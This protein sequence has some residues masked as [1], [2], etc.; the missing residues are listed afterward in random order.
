[1]S[2]RDEAA[3]V[4]AVR[5]LLAAAG[6]LHED[7]ARLVP[8][9]VRATAL[10]PEGVE[11]G[12]AS[13]E[14]EATEAELRALVGAAGDASHV[15]VILSANVFVAPLR[16]IALARAAAPRVTVR[17]SSRDP[18]LAEALVACAG[19]PAIAITRGKAIP[20]G[21]ER[22]DVYGRDETI[23]EVRA[24]ARAGVAVR[25]HGAGLGVAF[26]RAADPLDEAASA[27][28]ADVVPFD[29]RGCLSPR[30][31]LAEGPAARGAALAE[32][33]DASLAAWSSR[34]PRGALTADERAEAARWRDAIVFAGRVWDAADHATAH[35][36]RSAEAS[37][38]APSAV[39]P[40]GRHVLVVSAG[41]GVEAALRSIAP[42]VVTVGLL[43]GGAR[44]A[45][46]SIAALVARGARV[47][48]LGAMQRPPLDGPVDGRSIGA[49]V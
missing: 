35:V 22:V 29:Q 19:D 36:A 13:L 43:A 28:A 16:A 32:R 21:A 30:V 3:R 34:V 8:A 5:R 11:L 12:F 4:A 44:A 37:T 25:G 24:G 41:D 26:V 27:I 42:F 40:A 48:R 6:R 33:I 46:P 45:T 49:R 1:M 14:R 18:V 2:R 10:S 47:A 17:P 20:D 9:L 38:I 15:H 31:V 39:P 23:A 7:R